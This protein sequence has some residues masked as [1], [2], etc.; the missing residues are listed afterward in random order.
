MSTSN[1][2]AIV[3]QKS[4]PLTYHDELLS[5]RLANQATSISVNASMTS[6]KE[7]VYAFFGMNVT[8]FESY[9]LNHC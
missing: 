7:D 6:M 4:L 1:T 5:S 8:H 3:Q 9:L 2:A